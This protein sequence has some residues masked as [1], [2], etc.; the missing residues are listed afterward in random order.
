MTSFWK[1]KRL[2]GIFLIIFFTIVLSV[3]AFFNVFN[4]WQLQLANNFYGNQKPNNDIVIVA[5]DDDSLSDNVGLGNFEKWSRENFA[6]VL[7]NI[8]KYDPKVV[9]FDFIFRQKKDE[10]GDQK[11]YEALAKT[12]K[13]IIAYRLNPNGFNEEKGFYF[14]K[15]GSSEAEGVLPVLTT[16]NNLSLAAAKVFR[17][18][19]GAIRRIMPFIYDEQTGQY[20]ENL[21]FAIA[22][23]VFNA[24]LPKKP[25]ISPNNYEMEDNRGNKHKI[26]LEK[27]QMLINY[28]PI[29]LKGSYP[30]ISFVDVYKQ[31]YQNYGSDPVTLFKDK[32]VIIAPAALYFKDMFFTPVSK[33]TSVY[34]A[35]LH[36]NA[37]QTILDQAFL[38]NLTFPE[39]VALILLFCALG[40]FVFMYTKIRWS[41][42]FLLA[43]PVAYGLSAP[44]A[45]SKGLILDLVHPFLAI[46]AMF[47]AVY[48]Y[49][50]LTEFKEKIEL[51]GA[52]AKY[53]NPKLVDQIMAH[54]ENLKLGGEKRPITVLFTDIAHFTTI[55]ESLKPESLV[56][57]LNEYFEAMSQ[58]ILEEGGTLDKF[59]G[60]A[61]MAF[62][63]APLEQ[64]DHALRAATAALKMRQKL[65]DLLQ[66]W[67]TDP[68]LPGGEKKPLIDFRC[69]LSSG[70]V[71]VGNMGSTTRF[72]YTVMGDV[73]NLGSRLEGANKKYDTR[74]M[75]S[76]ATAEIVKDQF[77]MRE[78]DVIKVV[79]KTQPIK[80]FEV[81]NFKGQLVPEAQKLL[82]LYN[83]GIQM[84]HGRKFAEALEQFNKILETYP[85]DGPSKL[86]RQR[87]E[88]LRDFPPPADWDGVFEMGTK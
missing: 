3:T 34:G 5:I 84:Y 63:G 65:A 10:I 17:D 14:Q 55:S 43:L 72:D 20:Y 59:E 26:P 39:Q 40:A 67:Q 42:L 81:L 36:A 66:K 50:Y 2:I 27:G 46:V 45:F 19:D 76:E 80:V 4:L 8:N 54:P 68:P 71:I 88:V 21:A 33:E 86:Y 47:M 51:K 32:I 53:V 30:T 35:K 61:I 1:N 18:D 25:L 49:R 24:P 75:V 6:K 83:Q 79:G 69:G 7:D 85:A 23:S 44:F 60:D 9:A 70:E 16:L 74:I 82:E 78:L 62:F 22:R 73:V 77:E 87:C 38:R 64:P 11:F 13:A 12:K 57:L 31:D 29:T 37:V 15:N 48:I 41:V 56:A 52:F 28:T 58:V